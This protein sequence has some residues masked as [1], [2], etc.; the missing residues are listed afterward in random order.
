VVSVISV[1][2]NVKVTDKGAAI[3]RYK[4]LF[5]SDVLDEFELP[6]GELTVTIL[7]GLSIVSGS[8]AALSRAPTLLATV[9][10]DSLERTRDLLLQTGWTERGSL[11]T[12]GSLLAADPEGS[13]F[14]FIE[15]S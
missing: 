10:V 6:G 15:R 5:E 13:L 8:A 3:D 9:F 12:P 1:S 2:V 11:G 14:E 7:S 4:A